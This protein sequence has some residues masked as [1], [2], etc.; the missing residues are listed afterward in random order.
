MSEQKDR[1]S[2]FLKDH[3]HDLGDISFCTTSEVDIAMLSIMQETIEK[4]ER[5]IGLHDDTLYAVSGDK[6]IKIG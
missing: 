2:K 1:I 4:M 5:A 6:N 3:G